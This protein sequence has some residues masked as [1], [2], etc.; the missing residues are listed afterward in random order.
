MKAPCSRDM[1]QMYRN[2]FSSPEGRIVLSDLFSRLGLMDVA[3]NEVERIRHN[4]ACEIM[5]CCGMYM[6]DPV[7]NLEK[8]P[9]WENEYYART[10]E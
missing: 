3:M 10:S 4:V 1:M 8:T 2:V 9:N 6:T 7:S 5:D